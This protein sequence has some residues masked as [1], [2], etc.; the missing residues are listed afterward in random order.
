MKTDSGKVNIHGKEYKTVALRVNEFR[1][2]H[3]LDYSIE[4]DVLCAA[5]LV[6]VKAI[7][8][9]KDNFIVATGHAEEVRD[10]TNINKTSALENCETSAIGRA[11]AF[12]GYGGSEIASANEVSD[13][14]IQQAKRDVSDYMAKYSACLRENI[15][16]VLSVQS[17]IALYDTEPGLMDD[18]IRSWYDLPEEE[19]GLLYSVP[20]TKGG[21]FTTKER[22]FMK[23]PQFSQSALGEG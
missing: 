2:D 13:A 8:R 1:E 16:A 17:A 21:F 3:N 9:D 15:D 19:Q 11:L 14:I 4:T 5:D 22:Q 10:S 18:A 6:S 20:T 7:I 23:T 12:F